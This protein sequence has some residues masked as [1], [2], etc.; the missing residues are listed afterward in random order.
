M[1]KNPTGISYMHIEEF[2]GHAKPC[3][4]DEAKDAK[5]NLR[6]AQDLHPTV[7]NLQRL[8]PGQ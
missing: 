1:E 6:C 4:T 5:A 7:N 8:C 2:R 3:H